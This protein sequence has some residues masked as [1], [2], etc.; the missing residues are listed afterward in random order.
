MQLML[1]TCFASL[2]VFFTKL[3]MWSNFRLTRYRDF[4]QISHLIIKTL[5]QHGVFV[6]AKEVTLV[7]FYKLNSP[8]SQT[9]Y[10]LEIFLY[11]YIGNLLHS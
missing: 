10:I 2:L 7:H 11:L 5:H 6:T 8:F 9:W 1:P 3:F 4:P